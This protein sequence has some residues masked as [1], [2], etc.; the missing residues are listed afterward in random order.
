MQLNINTDAAV[1]FTNKLEKISRSAL[2]ISVRQ[3]LDGAAFDVK[4]NTMPN[5]AKG[6]FTQRKANFFKANSKVEKASGFNI[7][8]MRST[9]GFKPNSNKTQ[10]AIDDLE[11]QERGGKIK[12][13]EFVAMDSARAGNSHNKNVKAINTLSKLTLKNRIDAKSIKGVSNKQKFIR[14][15]FKAA[16]TNALVV[17]NFKTKQGGYT[18]SRIDSV[19]S[20]VKSRKLEIKRTPLYNLKSGRFVPIKAT[21]FMKRASMESGMKLE[22]LFIKNAKFNIQKYAN[23]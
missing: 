3:T 4:K 12:D 21:N 19:T 23:K 9:V 5:T 18:V 10:K 13:R 17:G 7:S 1:K 15:A 20:N 16:Q 2:P 8:T 11:Q 14:A 6:T 22:A